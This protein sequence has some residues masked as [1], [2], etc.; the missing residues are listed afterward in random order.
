MSGFQKTAPE[1]GVAAEEFCVFGDWGGASTS[2]KS[3]SAAEDFS[4]MARHMPCLP[5]LW[6][7]QFGAPLA[8]L[9]KFAFRKNFLNL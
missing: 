6:K 5:L 7:G 1:R 9:A 2:L 4:Q 8:L 3:G